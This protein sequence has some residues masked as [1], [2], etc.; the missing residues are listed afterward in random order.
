MMLPPHVPATLPPLP[1]PPS[2]LLAP[3]P[4]AAPSPASDF[5][6]APV[7]TPACAPAGPPSAA[8]ATRGVGARFSAT[9]GSCFPET[10]ESWTC[11][12]GQPGSEVG[13]PASA[14]GSEVDG[15]TSVARVEAGA[16]ALTMLASAAA[17]G[18]LSRAA[19]PTASVAVQTN[20]SE[21]EDD[22][23]DLLDAPAPSIACDVTDEE[24]N[25]AE[26]AGSERML[27]ESGAGGEE[28]PAQTLAGNTDALSSASP[29]E[30]SPEA[31]PGAAWT[32]HA[33]SV[34]IT[35]HSRAQVK[36]GPV[37]TSLRHAAA[38]SATAARLH[39]AAR[40]R[41]AARRSAS[42][43]VGTAEGLGAEHQ[44]IEQLQALPEVKVFSAPGCTMRLHTA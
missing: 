18:D 40:A 28:R 34:H 19:A 26:G 2:Y 12:V 23:S 17:I 14:A 44:V 15:P 27:G 7:A 22:A 13:A 3:S 41:R 43:V 29:S 5:T 42:Q 38:P 35:Y 11:W 39:A 32:M 31:A 16:R 4:A 9:P 6:E 10:P 8:D 33:G 1:P 21:A 30:S 25:V 20:E 24:V 37:D 36:G